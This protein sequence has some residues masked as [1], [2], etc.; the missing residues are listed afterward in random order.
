MRSWTLV[1]AVVGSLVG[2][3]SHASAYSALVHREISGV[4]A[5][6]SKVG[7]TLERQ[8]GLAGGLNNRIGNR[9]IAQRIA[10]GGELEDS[11]QLRA[12]NHFHNPLRPWAQAGGILGQSSIYWQQNPNQLFGSGTWSWPVARRRFFDF[13]T[14]PTQ[15]ERDA[16]LADTARALG[17]MMHL[18]QDAA[19]PPH[20]RNDAHLVHDGYEARVEELRGGGETSPERQRFLQYLSADPI[21]PSASILTPT[22]DARAPVPVARLIDRDTYGGTAASYSNGNSIGIAEYTNG[23]Y[24]SDD[25]IFLD[26]A[27]PRRE[28]LGAGFCEPGGAV[29]P[30]P[31]GSR[32]YF[33]KA[34][35]GDAVGHFV[36]EGSLALPL[37]FRGESVLGF[38]LD[39]RVYHDYA[40]RLL[41]RAIGYSAALL[42]YFFRGRLEVAF[43][44]A[45]MDPARVLLNVTNGSAEPL[46]PGTL[47]VYTDDSSGTRQ[48][49]PGATLAFE[50]AV[51]PG[52]LLPPIPLAASFQ[53]SPLAVVYHGRLGGEDEAVIGRVLTP[54]TVVE[55][56]FRGPSDWMLRTA[57]GIFPLGIG[58][59]PNRVKWGDRDNTLVTAQWSQFRGVDAV[60][61]A[62]R[63]NRPEGSSTV[64]LRPDG[65]VDLVPLGSATFAGA[66]IDLETTVTFARST[67]VSQKIAL[68]D[69]HVFSLSPPDGQC[70]GAGVQTLDLGTFPF[71][72]TV[73][74][75]LQLPDP[76]D[77]LYNWFFRD[78]SLNRD[79]DI[80]ATVPLFFVR[81]IE[82]ARVPC[83]FRREDGQLVLGGSC[84]TIFHDFPFPSLMVFVVNL[85]RRSVVAESSDHSVAIS[86]ATKTELLDEDIHFI[87]HT[88]SFTDTWRRV[89]S[90]GGPVTGPVVG[91]VTLSDGIIELTQSGFYRP[92][93]GGAG[94]AEH[95]LVDVSSTNDLA[96]GPDVSIRLTHVA[97]LF[98]P[99]ATFLHDIGRASGTD[100]DY[101]V[102]GSKFCDRDFS[103]TWV[104]IRWNPTNGT[105]TRLAPLSASPQ[106]AFN[107]T[108]TSASRSAAMV[109]VDEVDPVAVKRVQ[110]THLVTAQEDLVFRGDLSGQYRLLGPDLLFNTSEARFHRLTAALD[111]LPGPPLLAPGGPTAGEYHVVGRQ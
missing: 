76:S 89:D 109:V 79:G 32:V 61:T 51:A 41:P 97:R 77:N 30:C 78:V 11:P 85:T 103:T 6:R 110:F 106:H 49:V 69:C 108:L 83:W 101:T 29:P 39:D 75:V 88:P 55:Q 2:L 45:P 93:L 7:E 81:P 92:E 70:T 25:T 68:I 105:V 44:E 72:A 99:T 64:P 65:R 102:V 100:G 21:F 15:S 74:L 16:A 14:L 57:E 10:E 37:R 47:T 40:A 9:S 28:S 94:F 96:L 19:A 71:T 36:A 73:P 42:D 27:L 84:L 87:S 22:G 18:I 107:A 60:F 53:S 38:I 34:G 111:P 43:G 80:L 3:A 17:Q 12:L 8:Y 33:P 4:A 54:P 24:V 62:Y 67:Q 50:T 52:E 98:C 95:T 86:Y 46:G 90:A 23:G 31:P 48:P 59:G 5:Q 13:L 58:P 26:F 104:P 20:V 56:I 91:E 63:I 35:D 1:W 66:P 82:P